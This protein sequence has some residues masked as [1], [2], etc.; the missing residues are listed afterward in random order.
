[1]LVT[2]ILVSLVAHG[3]WGLPLAAVLPVAGAFLLLD[4]GFVAANAHKIPAA[5]GS[6]WWSLPCR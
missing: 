2:T 6:R 3:R 4:I 5:A 1:M